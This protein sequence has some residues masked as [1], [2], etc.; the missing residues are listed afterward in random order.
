MNAERY[1]PVLLVF[2]FL[3]LHLYAD[4]QITY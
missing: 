3:G 1:I 2:L 4:P